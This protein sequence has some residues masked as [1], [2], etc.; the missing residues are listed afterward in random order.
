MEASSLL[1]TTATLGALGAGLFA[2]GHHAL[3]GPDH[4]AGVA[5][6]AA[7][8]G[9]HAWRVGAAWGLGH[10]AGALAAAALALALRESVPGIEDRLSAVSERLV[11]A[12]L[13]VVGAWGLR[14]ALRRG[15]H[16]HEHEGV[17][18]AHAHPERQHAHSAFSIGLLHG[19]AGLAHLLAVLPALALPGVALPAIY[20]GGY[21]LASLVAL[22]L[23]AA[24]LGRCSSSF[25]S[26]RAWVGTMS[27]AALGVGLFW[28]VH[29]P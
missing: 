13:C 27:A 26:V 21:A 7:R 22:T 11:G 24:T 8:A 6:F 1:T 2:G 14:G 10:T 12:V 20:L 28:L 16:E 4:M 19:A 17:R 18:H 25:G 5:P 3:A 23:V 9:R 29:G 15:A